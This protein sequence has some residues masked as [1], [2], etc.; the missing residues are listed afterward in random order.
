MPC[1]FYLLHVVKECCPVISDKNED[2]FT[3][4]SA[5]ERAKV[6][7][8]HKLWQYDISW[9]KTELCF[10]FELA[11]HANSIAGLQRHSVQS[12]NRQI[13]LETEHAANRE[14]L[15]HPPAQVSVSLHFTLHVQ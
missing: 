10:D 1:N 7:K 6:L 5:R 15:T 14:A 4:H 9:Q 3:H 12:A 13:L 11:V 8:S 2:A